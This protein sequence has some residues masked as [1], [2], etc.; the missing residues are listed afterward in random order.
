MDTEVKQS[1]HRGAMTAT[2]RRVAAVLAEALAD[3]HPGTRWSPSPTPTYAQ[4]ARRLLAEQL[5]DDRAQTEPEG[6]H[7]LVK[8]YR[9]RLSQEE[10]APQEA[11]A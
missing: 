8:G 3:D 11:A 6:E 7:V 10:T 9:W 1:R 5:D 4:A 2:E